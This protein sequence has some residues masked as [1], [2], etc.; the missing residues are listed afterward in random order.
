MLYGDLA[1]ESFC[2]EKMGTL[3]RRESEVVQL[4]EE[5]NEKRLT[6]NLLLKNCQHAATAIGNYAMGL[7]DK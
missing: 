7:W 3:A 4:I 6:Y 2:W 1:R 5:I